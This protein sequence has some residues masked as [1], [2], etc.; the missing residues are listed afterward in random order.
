MVDGG[1]EKLRYIYL[2]YFFFSRVTLFK[3]SE[4][5]FIGVLLLFLVLIF[6]RGFL[7]GQYKNTGLPNSEYLDTSMRR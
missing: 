5:G 7:Q 3:I 1:N 2:F 4:F 6:V